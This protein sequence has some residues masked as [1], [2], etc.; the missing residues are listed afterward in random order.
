M[1]LSSFWW[2]ADTVYGIKT[3]RQREVFMYILQIIGLGRCAH[4]YAD[5]HKAWCADLW[6]GESAVVM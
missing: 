6:Y 1:V 3:S 4:L 5:K 2:G